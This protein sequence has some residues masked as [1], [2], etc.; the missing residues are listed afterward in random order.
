MHRVYWGNVTISSHLL[1]EHD[2]ELDL[3]LTRRRLGVRPNSVEGISFEARALVAL[4]RIPEMRGRLEEMLRVPTNVVQDRIVAVWLDE[5]GGDLE[6]HGYVEEA[7]AVY[8]RAADWCRGRPPAELKDS[9]DDCARALYHAGEFAKA[10]TVFAKLAKAD[11]TNVAWQANLGVIAART[12]DEREVS[13]VDRWLAAQHGPYLAGEPTF[14]RARIAAVRGERE[15]AVSLLR[16]AIDQGATVFGGGFGLHSDPDFLP[17]RG[18][19]PYD[20][21]LRPKE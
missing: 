8:R 18:Y 1:G 13:R 17:M 10:R 2:R 16:L 6:A 12:G 4:G 7:R 19:A 11:P 5:V 9:E 3:E 14:D 20:E 15:R 21:L